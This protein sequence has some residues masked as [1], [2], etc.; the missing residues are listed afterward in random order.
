MVDED[1]VCFGIDRF[2]LHEQVLNIFPEIKNNLRMSS[3][4][5]YNKII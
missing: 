2:Y 1:A 4:F 3:V 5:F